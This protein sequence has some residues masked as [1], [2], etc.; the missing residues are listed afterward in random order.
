MLHQMLCN[1]ITFRPKL[2]PWLTNCILCSRAHCPFQAGFWRF[3]KSAYLL[4]ANSEISSDFQRFFSLFFCFLY[5]HPCTHLDATSF[6]NQPP[7][8]DFLAEPFALCPS[9]SQFQFSHHPCFLC[10]PAGILPTCD[11]TA[12]LLSLRALL[13]RIQTQFLLSSFI[14]CLSCVTISKYFISSSAFFV[15]TR[16]L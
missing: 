16:V 8:P 7:S 10:L 2:P 5:S 15:I 13:K 4:H 11:S 1:Y 3:E 9:C 12:E 6:L 14:P